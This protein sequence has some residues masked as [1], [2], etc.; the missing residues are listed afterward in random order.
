VGDNCRLHVIE[1]TKAMADLRAAATNRA[2]TLKLER[3]DGE[4]RTPSKEKLDLGPIPSDT[5][6]GCRQDRQAA[7]QVR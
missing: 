3:L 5:N 7:G 2:N 1:L 6:P 4:I